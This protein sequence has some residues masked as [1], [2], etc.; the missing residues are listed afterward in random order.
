MLTESRQL[1]MNVAG[2]NFEK[3]Y[4]FDSSFESGNLDMVV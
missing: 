1:L 3:P 2:Q 4:I